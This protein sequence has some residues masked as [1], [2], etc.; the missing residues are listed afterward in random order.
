MA[1]QEVGLKIDV[2]VSSVGNMKQQLRA[3]TNELIAMNEKFGS[4]SKEA[5]AAAQKVAGLKDAIGDAKALADTFNPDKKFVALGGAVQGAVAGF[6]ALQGAMGLFG[7]ESKE[8]EKMLLKVQSAMALQQ[9]ISGVAGAIDSFKLLAGQIASSS[10]MLKANAVATNVAS[11]AMKMFGVSVATT[12]NAFRVLKGAIV[13]TG[14]GALIV[15]LGELVNLLMDVTDSSEEAAEAQKKLEKAQKDAADAIALQNKILE[16]QIDLSKRNTDTAIKRA[17]ATGASEEEIT[18]ITRD[19]ILKR[20]KLLEDDLE[21]RGIGTDQ[22]YE[23]LKEVRKINNELEDFDL[24]Q[25]IKRREKSD[26]DRQK[27]IEKNAE[28]TKKENENKLA[29][30]KVLDD[31]RR[32]KLTE[33]QREEE[34]IIKKFEESKKVL[35][36][37]GKKDF[38]AIEEQKELALI[39]I[40]KKYADQEAQRIEQNAQRTKE[41]QIAAI[42]DEN[43]RAKAENELKLQTELEAETKR[44]KD[45]ELGLEQYLI[46]L[47]LIRQRVTNEQKAKDE[48][49]KNIELEKQA[50]KLLID[51]ENEELSFQE[52]LLKV[53]EREALVNQIVFASE[54]EKTAFI[55][56][57]S[58]ARQQ[59]AEAEKN[60]LI[61]ASDAV[62]NTL[63]NASQVLGEETEAGKALAIASATISMITSAQKAYESMIGIPYVGPVL[64]PISAALAVAAGLKN[65]DEISKV[66]APGMKG[67]GG[68]SRPSI[69]TAAPMNPQLNTQV[70]AT[71]VNTAA[72]NQLGN[73]A[74][75][76]YVLNSDIQNAEQRNAYINRNASIGNP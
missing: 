56:A 17:K 71:Q 55:K 67:G 46:N 59:I 44:Y 68:V 24:D 60:A 53:Q 61:A 42:A 5:V 73:Q 40:R 70:R 38:T 9:G 8:V 47:A 50:E 21:K 22:F 72:V 48:E 14:I 15:V 19:G 69:S 6:S 1:K 30:E 34:D 32:D 18:K 39:E 41:L 64:A 4:A 62:A 10:F 25:Q 2:D 58:D 74:T 43:E 28:K 35:Q 65:I 20:K 54:E 75:R 37:A 36:A 3:A 33:R 63:A 49:E 11:G 57:N 29:A 26:A 31:A 51:A 16:E 27:R 45:G 76:A 23:K 52:R 12:S 66:K 13:A 7:G